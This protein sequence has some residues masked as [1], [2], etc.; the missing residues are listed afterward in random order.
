MNINYTIAADTCTPPE[1]GDWPITCSDNCIKDVDFTVPANITLTDPGTFTLNANMTM[2]SAH[3]EI[4]K[5]DGCEI[6][7]NS[8]GSI[9]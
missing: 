8:A 2:T 3:W 7:I 9:R 4:F 6:V 5:E 1:S